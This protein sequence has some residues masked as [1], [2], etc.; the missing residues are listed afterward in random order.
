MGGKEGY[1]GWGRK[2]YEWEEKIN[3]KCLVAL[4]DIHLPLI[5]LSINGSDVS[6]WGIGALRGLP[7]LR[8]FSFLEFNSARFR[9]P[10]ERG[11]LA[12]GQ[13]SLTSFA[14]GRRKVD[15]DESDQGSVGGFSDDSDI[16]QHP[17]DPDFNFDCMHVLKGSGLPLT[18]LHL[19]S[20]KSVLTAEGFSGLEGM[21]LTSLELTNCPSITDET[22]L[23]LGGLPLQS[24]K[25][26]FSGSL[27]L[28]PVG[29]EGLRG[30]PLTCFHLLISP[31]AAEIF[32]SDQILQCL[33][34]APLTDLQL[35]NPSTGKVTDEGMAFLRGKPLTSLKLDDWS[36]VSDEGFSELSGMPLKE[37]EMVECDLLD[38]GLQILGGL[39]LEVLDVCGVSFITDVG[40]SFLHGSSFKTLKLIGCGPLSDEAV[41]H[42]QASLPNLEYLEI[43]C[44]GNTRFSYSSVWRWDCFQ[45]YLD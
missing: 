24:L 35:T 42:L 18:H 8:T 26:E 32:E 22:F 33:H 12:L 38:A 39:N 40:L 29:W 19:D 2:T 17:V 4:P 31:F 15:R 27:G 36:Q 37:L 30:F 13:L 9:R 3:D 14:M 5:E 43:R 28:T 16:W 34:G 6:A 11:L 10:S 20:Q 23:A 44:S 25:L 41:R 1:Y 7:Q 21:P 45:G